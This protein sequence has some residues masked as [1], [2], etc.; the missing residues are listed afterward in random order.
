MIY[1]DEFIAQLFQ[2]EKVIIDPP[3]REF[4][5]ERGYMKKN[6]TLQ[7]VDGQFNFKG[8]IRYNTRFPENF[9][10]GLDYNP[11]EEKGTV[12]LIR[13]NRNH[14]ENVVFPYHA[15]C[16]IHRA[17]ALTLNEGLKPESHIEQTTEYSRLDEA[18]QYFIR[19]V[20][21]D[22]TQAEKYFP[23]KQLTLFDE[24][25]GYFKPDPQGF[26]QLP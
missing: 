16:H 12:C 22:K 17:T 19:V 21:L 4:R 8:F 11:R 18:I 23:P 1:T 15:S 24:H 10:I 5:E 3:P 25:D 26:Q 14:G 7:S 13:C 6:F 9:S 20:L 2:C